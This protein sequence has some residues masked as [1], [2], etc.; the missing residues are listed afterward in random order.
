MQGTRYG[1]TYKLIK[2]N[3]KDRKGKDKHFY[4][5]WLK[6][7]DNSSL[8]FGSFENFKEHYKEHL[9]LCDIEALKDKKSRYI[10]MS[11]F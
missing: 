7:N 6:L 10:Q 5:L 4:I 11:L 9:R 2:K 3:Y 8:S 1:H